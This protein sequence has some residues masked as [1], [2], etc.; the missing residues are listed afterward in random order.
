VG[1][2][3]RDRCWGAS[4]A[5]QVERQV[6]VRAKHCMGVTN[7]QCIPSLSHSHPE[8]ADLIQVLCITCRVLLGAILSEGPARIPIKS[9]HICVMRISISTYKSFRACSNI[10]ARVD[11]CET[12]TRLSERSG[13][14]DETR[15]VPAF[16]AGPSRLA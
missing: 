6:T 12:D 16:R 8:S 3:P 7:R 14:P 13:R 5:S 11:S 1:S 4:G 10:P 9:A 15:C 2:S